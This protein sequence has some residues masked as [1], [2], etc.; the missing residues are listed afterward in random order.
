MSA[1]HAALNDDH[2]TQ[3]DRARSATQAHE[4]NEAVV[5]WRWHVNRSSVSDAARGNSA[6]RQLLI[7]A[8]NFALLAASL[9][10]SASS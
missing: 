5:V 1:E 7:E 9:F 10:A 3:A 4:I 8:C 6:I 2:A